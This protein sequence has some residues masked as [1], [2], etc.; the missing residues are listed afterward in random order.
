M[1]R[2]RTN[3]FCTK[4]RREPGFSHPLNLFP[5][6]LIDEDVSTIDDLTNYVLESLGVSVVRD[7]RQRHWRENVQKDRRPWTAAGNF[8]GDR[9]ETLPY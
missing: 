9:I 6:F 8:A 7:G 5:E 2:T 1:H 4:F 3:C